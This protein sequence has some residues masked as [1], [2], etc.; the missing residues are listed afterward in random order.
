MSNERLTIPGVSEPVTILLDKW[1]IP[2]IRAGNLMDMFFAQ[3]FNAA[4]D[5]LWQIDLWRKRG[6]G[7][8]AADFGP[9]YLEQ[10]RAARLFVYRGDMASEWACY[11][12][13][14][15]D[16]CAAFAGG[17]NA[18]IDL[19]AREP[20]RLPVEFAE[21]GT[22]PAKWQAE[23]VVRIRSHGW[24]RNALSEVT[25]ANVVAQAG[26]DADLLRQNLN[27]PKAV[28][29]PEGLD[30]GSIPMAVL[31]TFK[32]GLLPVSFDAE[33]LAASMEQAS[34]WRRI[35]PLGDVVRESSGQG[36]NNWVIA[37]SKTET[38][39]P[40]LAN[41]P[42]RAHAV[43]SLRYI[44][45][46][47]C[48]EFDGIGAGEPVVPGIM[49]GHNG[50]IGFGLTLFFGP[51]Q[52]D[53]Y[54][55]DIHPEDCDLYRYQ[56]GW[57]RMR[58]VE[59]TVAVLGAPD[60]TL[61]LKFT[62]HGPV[63]YED[64]AVLRAYAVRSVWSEPGSAAY[65]V[66][67]SSMRRKNHADFAADMQRW[68]V[69]AV[70]QVYADTAGTIGWLVAG[71]SPIRPNWD[72]LLPVPG[73]GAY[74]WQGFYRA[75]GLPHVLNPE[76]GFVATANE[77]NVPPDWPLPAEKIGHEWIE[78]SR[79]TRIA[80]AFAQTPVHSIATSCELQTDLV[81]V[82]AR[83]LSALLSG[84]TADDAAMSAALALLQNWDGTLASGSAA[85]ALSEVWWSKHLRPGIFAVKVADPAVRTLMGPGDI[86]AILAQ[87][88]QP[89]G[90]FPS[91]AARDALL[92]ET[93]RRAYAE[94]A[95]RMGDD[96]AA[97]TWGRLHHGYF[98]HALASVGQSSARNIGPLPMGGSESTPMNA[99]YRYGDFRVVL[100][101]SF[102]MVLDVGAWDNSRCINAPGQSGDVRSPHYGDLAEA[103]SKGEYVPLLYS[104]SAVD[105]ATQSRIELHP[106]T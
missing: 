20:A 106:A 81:S 65:F 5:R 47:T 92:L 21:L 79:A 70:N 56:D 104:R 25:R 57:E 23:D 87:L 8:L 82:P 13:D 97:W 64:R 17:I 1:G 55:Y 42:H 62:R 60:Q 95:D 61:Q 78:S 58:I 53:V 54:V 34:D 40:I 59:E 7:L 63:I 16:I 66:S 41:D 19:V 38:G 101:A 14:A 44:V 9:G 32:L 105:Q 12:P 28:T 30:P 98:E 103:W 31:D 74:E 85:A 46:L 83:R 37:G 99:Q 93:L 24:M 94:C 72:G 27:P 90:F 89:E 39:R 26:A 80:E 36:S 75:G 4:R 88:E 2:H 3:G 48:P 86:D 76:A 51:D 91:P 69:P 6:L 45:H 22:T 49:A 100:G 96:P 84:L 73:H 18:Y 50:T 29:M 11:S 43:P 68:A 71:F 10:D 67:I 35:T 15:E 77:Q 33:R 52:E 102:R